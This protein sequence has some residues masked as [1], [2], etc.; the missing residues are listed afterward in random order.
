MGCKP[1]VTGSIRIR[2]S[3][4]PA[5]PGPPSSSRGWVPP[6]LARVREGR[7]TCGRGGVVDDHHELAGR[8]GRGLLRDPSLFLPDAVE[9]DHLASGVHLAVSDLP[10]LVSLEEPQL[11]AE[12]PD[13]ELVRSL[14]VAI[15]EQ[16]ND[17]RKFVHRATVGELRH[18]RDVL[19]QTSPEDADPG[20]RVAERER[21]LVCRHALARPVDRGE[22]RARLE[23]RDTARML[24]VQ[25]D[26]LLGDPG[27]EHRLPVMALTRAVARTTSQAQL[28]ASRAFVTEP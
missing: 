20:A 3:P 17:V 19:V 12:R 18:G 10:I 1:E 23:R 4:W 16:R 15:D 13:E 25:V 24:E 5:G 27:G 8:G 28:T 7:A 14:D 2:S 22:E 9:P 11:E 6:V 21:R 26:C